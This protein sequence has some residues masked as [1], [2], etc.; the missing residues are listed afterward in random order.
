MVSD[1]PATTLGE[2]C[3]GPEGS[4]QTGPFGSQLHQSDYTEVGIP[5]IMPTNIRDGRVI[6]EE[7]AR[8]SPEE[9]DRLKR[10]RVA[11][12]D[13]V[14]SRRGEIDKC[15]VVTQREVGWVCGTGCLLARPVKTKADAKFIGYCISTPGAKDWLKQNAVGL[16]MPNLNTGI[17]ARLP[18]PAMGVLKQAEIAAILGTLDAKIELNRDTASTLESTARALFQSWFVNFD[19]VHAKIEGRHTGLPA[20]IAAHFPDSFD[21]NGLPRG[22]RN[23]RADE[24]ASLIRE[25]VEP[26]DVDPMTPYVGLDYIEKRQIGLTDWGCASEVDSIKTKFSKDDLLFGKL[27]PYFHKVAIAPVAGI[28][29]SDIFVF[30]AKYREDRAYM[31][32]AFSQDSFVA[33]ATGGVTGTRMPRADWSH[34][35]AQLFPSGADA[36]MTAFSDL[37]LDIFASTSVMLAE[38]RALAA[39]RDALLP[40]LISGELRVPEKVAKAVAA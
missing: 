17:L 24:I 28:C 23:R 3:D 18:I 25:G 2:L 6:D 34:M 36:V 15:A 33:S 1:Q 8:I 31:Y 29:S 39:T 21:D 40:K 14:F 20:D 12:G 27:R 38:G 35:S 32:L 9:A 4:I 37:V 26:R 30:R 10:H 5:V 11:L 16:V 19:P 13:I 22:W 7:I